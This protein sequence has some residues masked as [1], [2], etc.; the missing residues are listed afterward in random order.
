MK[1]YTLT[2]L[3]LLLLQL[4]TAIPTKIS[5]Y[6]YSPPN[7]KNTNQKS[8]LDLLSPAQKNEIDRIRFKV[9]KGEKLTEEDRKILIDINNYVA[10][11]KLGDEKFE[12]F[13]SLMKKKKSQDGLTSE[14]ENKLKTFITQIQTP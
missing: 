14:E 2:V 6:T 10:R 13:S 7:S 4:F 11:L 5:L 8:T 9:E 12:E 1:N 3:V